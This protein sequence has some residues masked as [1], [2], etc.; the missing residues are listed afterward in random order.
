ME[1]K[2]KL[3]LSG[4][5]CPYCDVPTQLVP[6]KVIYGDDSY[7]MF[8]SCQQCFA[9]CG[10]HKGGTESLGSIANYNL[11]GLRNKTHRIFDP[12]WRAMHKQENYKYTQFEAR[13]ACYMWLSVMMGVEMEYCHIGMFTEQQCLTAIHLINKFNPFK[14]VVYETH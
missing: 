7:G 4:K 3:I 11:R 13:T 1:E 10:C 12:L 14:T 6:S 5:W 9:Y 2:D 8:H